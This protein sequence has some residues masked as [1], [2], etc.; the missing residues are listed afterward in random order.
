MLLEA[1]GLFSTSP[2]QFGQQQQNSNN[3]YLRQMY[4][5]SGMD[6]GYSNNTSQQMPYASEPPGFSTTKYMTTPPPGFDNHSN[7]GQGPN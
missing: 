5:G 6:F 4:R 3:S 2:N 1:R 7:H